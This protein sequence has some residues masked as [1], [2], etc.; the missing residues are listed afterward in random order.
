MARGRK[1][2]RPKCVDSRLGSGNQYGTNSEHIPM[3]LVPHPALPAASAPSGLIARLRRRGEAGLRPEGRP[4]L[5][6]APALAECLPGGVLPLGVLHEV[7]PEA[8]AVI[9]RGNVRT[10]VLFVLTRGSVL[11]INAEQIANIFP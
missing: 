6:M 1:D 3:T 10:D 9:R 7:E 5:R 4:G 11:G 2:S 8:G